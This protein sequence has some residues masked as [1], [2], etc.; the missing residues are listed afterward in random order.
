M[1]YTDREDLNYAGML[2]HLGRTRTP[3]LNAL[4][5]INATVVND[6]NL[7]SVISSGQIRTVSSPYFSVAQPSVLTTPSQAVKTEAE[8]V[9]PTATTITRAEDTNVVQIQQKLAEVTY[10]KQSSFAMRS[11]INTNEAYQPMSEL[12]FQVQRNMQQMAADL[13][14]SLIKGTYAAPSNASTAGATRGLENAISTNATA[15]GSVTLNKD[16]IDSTLALM[17]SSGAPLENIVAVGNSYQIKK[18]NDI[19]GYAVQSMNVGGTTISR[20]ATPYGQFSV[21]LDNNV[22]T[23]T[24]MF[25]EMAICKLVLLPVNGQYMIVEDKEITGAAIAKHLYIQTGLDYGAE[26]YHGI[27]TGLLAS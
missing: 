1:A 8:T 12:D 5:G 24:L 16:I 7:E 21:M 26:E 6:Y 9:S 14:F 4:I 3:F 18:I 23:T 11:G 22:T 2:F 27:I 19:Y 20:V 15:A 17:I 13:D 25:V 10:A